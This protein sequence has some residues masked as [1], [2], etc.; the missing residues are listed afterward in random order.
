MANPPLDDRPAGPAR[1]VPQRVS[2]DAERRPGLDPFWYRH[3]LDAI[4]ACELV[5]DSA[6]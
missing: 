3:L 4:D 5:A 6:A 2:E 1:P